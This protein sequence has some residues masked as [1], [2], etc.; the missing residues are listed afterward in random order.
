MSR[1]EKLILVHDL[2]G[3][4]VQ[5][6]DGI[7]AGQGYVRTAAT[8]IAEDFSPILYEEGGPIA[9]VLSTPHDDWVACFTSLGVDEEGDLADALARALQQPVVYALFAAEQD[10][11]VYRYWEQG[12]LREEVLPD[13]DGVER[14]DEDALLDRLVRHGISPA[15]VDDRASGFGEEHVVVGYAVGDA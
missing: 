11:Y 6:L 5:A 9:F 13:A 3:S 10:L 1:S 2:P 12:D 8:T 14:L 15:L 7:L 4:I